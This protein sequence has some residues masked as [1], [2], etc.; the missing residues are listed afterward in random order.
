MID[1][2]MKLAEAHGIK[3]QYKK[4]VSSGNDANAIHKVRAGVKTVTISAPTRY[5]HTPQTSS[6]PMIMIAR[7]LSQPRLQGK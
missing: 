7:L 2:V 5:I 4:Y 1:F 3:A 6:A